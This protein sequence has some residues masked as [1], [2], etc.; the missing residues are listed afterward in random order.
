MIS[1]ARHA[2]K[3]QEMNHLYP[4]PPEGTEALLKVEQFKGPIWEP[5]CG[6]GD[7]AEVLKTAGHEVLSTD[8]I[9]YGYGRHEMARFVDFLEQSH[10]YCPNIVTN[11]PFKIAEKFLL[12]AIDLGAEKI[13]LLVRLHFLEGVKRAKIFARHPPVRVWVFPWRL[14]IVPDKVDPVRAGGAIPYCWVIWEK[15]FHG[16]TTLG[17][18]PENIDVRAADVADPTPSDLLPRSSSNRR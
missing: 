9:D 15:G 5:A 2:P 11:P 13:A 18:L 7:M 8:L 12:H 17:W 6:R 1:G 14:C 16:K 4:T 10:L 3:D